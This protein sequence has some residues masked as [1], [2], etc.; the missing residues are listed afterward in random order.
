MKEN[1]MCSGH[2]AGTQAFRE[3]WERIFEKNKFDPGRPWFHR[4]TGIEADSVAG[5]EPTLEEFK[6]EIRSRVPKDFWH[7]IVITVSED[8]LTLTRTLNAEYRPKTLY[9]RSPR[10]TSNFCASPLLRGREGLN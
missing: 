1:L 8:P 10:E 4:K 6:A 9:I 7:R 3:G 5:F 2:K